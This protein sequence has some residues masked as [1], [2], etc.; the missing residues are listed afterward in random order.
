MDKTWKEDEERAEEEP[1]KPWCE[2]RP[3]RGSSHFEGKGLFGSGF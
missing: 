2:S 3:R 1:I